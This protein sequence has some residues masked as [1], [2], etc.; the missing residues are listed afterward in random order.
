M[1]CTTILLKQTAILLNGLLP[2]RI[3]YVCLFE[4]VSRYSLTNVDA[5]AAA[6]QLSHMPSMYSAA[7]VLLLLRPLLRAHC[8]EVH[9]PIPPCLQHQPP[10]NTTLL[11]LRS[12]SS[13]ELFIEAMVRAAASAGAGPVQDFFF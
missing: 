6:L 9:Y 7:S 11:N 8:T 10:R 12:D 13:A 2:A 3:S 5:N 4:R 1:R